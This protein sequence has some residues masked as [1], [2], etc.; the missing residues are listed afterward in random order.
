MARIES[1]LIT[2]S[3]SSLGAGNAWSS[4]VFN[5]YLESLTVTHSSAFNST[6]PLT[7]YRGTTSD[8]IFTIKKVTTG[9]TTYIPR[10]GVHTTTGGLLGSSGAVKAGIPLS[11]ER[12][13]MTV[14]S[15]SDRTLGVTV[16]IKINGSIIKK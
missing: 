13:Y 5:G 1:E 11:N 10:Y 14:A 3:L 4:G 8:Q 7:I 12:L 16:N 6:A 2:V 9:T 15:S